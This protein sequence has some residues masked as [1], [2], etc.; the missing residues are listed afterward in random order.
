MQDLGYFDSSDKVPSSN[1]PQKDFFKFYIQKRFKNDF[2]SSLNDSIFDYGEFDPFY[3]LSSNLDGLYDRITEKA[4]E[5]SFRVVGLSKYFNSN[6]LKEV[7]FTPSISDLIEDCEASQIINFVD[8]GLVNFTDLKQIAKDMVYEL[9]DVC[10]LESQSGSLGPVQEAACDASLAMFMR[11]SIAENILNGFFAFSVYSP[12]SVMKNKVMQSF[13]FKRLK[14]DLLGLNLYAKFKDRAAK[15]VD[16]RRQAGEA[17]DATS[18]VEC[19]KFLFKE[20]VK[21]NFNFYSSLKSP[22]PVANF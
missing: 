6:I 10:N 2:Q 4:I 7:N 8:G 16:R 17:I 20:N 13:L 3:K 22:P 15:I 1:S 5:K 12:E 14:D 19:L 18:R 11:V 9:N 21:K